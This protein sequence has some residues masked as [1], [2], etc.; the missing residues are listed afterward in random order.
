MKRGQ[1][2]KRISVLRGRTRRRKYGKKEYLFCLR[3]FGGCSC[4]GVGVSVGMTLR[5]LLYP[6]RITIDDFL[7]PMGSFG[8][9][10]TRLLEG[11]GMRAVYIM[12][13]D[14]VCNTDN[15]NGSIEINDGQ[16]NSSL[17][18]SLSLLKTKGMVETTTHK[19]KDL[20]FALVLRGKYRIVQRC[21]RATAR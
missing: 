2:I 18:L 4:D 14:D 11:L 17:S 16:C 3:S 19:T 15:S 6:R 9:G 10:E 13:T 7:S 21:R 20:V 8:I 12:A 5:V 1:Q